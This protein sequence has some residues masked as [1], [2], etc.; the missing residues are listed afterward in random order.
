MTIDIV[1]LMDSITEMEEAIKNMD[2][3]IIFYS[4][5]P[6]LYLERG[7]LKY[8]SNDIQGAVSDYDM[9]RLMK[10]VGLEEENTEIKQEKP[11]TVYSEGEIVDL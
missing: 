1:S 2:T 10:F 6:E 9:F 7:L 5:S 11:T 8:L 4:F 3:A